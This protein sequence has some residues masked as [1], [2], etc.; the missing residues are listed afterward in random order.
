MGRRN[1]DNRELLWARPDDRLYRRPGS[2]PRQNAGSGVGAGQAH[3]PAGDIPL[4][5]SSSGGGMKSPY[6]YEL[7]V[8]LAPDHWIWITS[9]KEMTVEHFRRLHQYLALQRETLIED[10]REEATNV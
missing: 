9:N 8:P 6:T 1:R 5:T 3:K 10:E 7:R 2:L 4:A